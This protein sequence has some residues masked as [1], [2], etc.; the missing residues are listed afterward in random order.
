MEIRAYFS[1]DLPPP[2][3]ATE[4]Y[5]RDLLT[6]YQRRLARARSR[7]ASSQP[8]K[9]EEKQAAERD[10]IERVQD[11]KLE[12]DSFS[13][14]EGYRGVAFH[15]PRRH[16]KRS[17]TSTRTDGLE[18]EITQIIKEMVGEKVEDRRASLAT[19][20]A[21]DADACRPKGAERL[22]QA[23][24]A[25]VRRPGGQGRQGDPEDL[26]ALLIVQPEKPLHR[27]PSCATSI[28]T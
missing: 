14:H 24:S 22:A 4:R 19:T 11:Q 18:Y 21:H 20:A 27:R 12:A 13:V 3:N 5:V 1:K 25:D 28:S 23:V 7:C 16:A 26:K 6:E 17:S 15:V 9:D 10:G 8:V 2:Y